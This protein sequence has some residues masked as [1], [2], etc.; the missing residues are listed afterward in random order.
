M[1]ERTPV[2]L[3]PGS[4]D[5]DLAE[6]KSRSVRGLLALTGRTFII[7][8]LSTAATFILTV[9][10]SPE[11]YGTFFLVSAVI[12]FLTYF[13]DIGLAAAL[14]QR[15]E[16]LTIKDLSTTFTVQQILVFSLVTVLLLLTTPIR[17]HYQL[18]QEGVFLMWS[19]AISLVLSSLKTIPTA[20]LEREL[21]FDKL[22]WP[23][24]AENIAYNLVVVYFAWKGYGITS[25]SFAVLVRGIVG[26]VAIYLIRPW[27]PTLGVHR[28]SLKHLLHFGLPYQL[29]TLLAV[30]KDDGMTLVLGGIVGQ[31]GL[32]YL[33]WANKWVSLPLRFFMDNITKVAFP[34]YAR[35]QHE[36]AILK[37]GVEK[38]IFFMALICFP[39]FMGMG[40]L[41]KPM[42]GLIPRYSKWE[43]ALFPFYMYLI[44]AAWASISTPLTNTLNA[45]GKIKSTFKLMIMWTVLTWLLMPY[46]GYHYG[47]RGVSLAAAIIAFS[48][49]VV[50]Y[51]VNQTIKLNYWSILRSPILASI[52]LGLVAW[53]FTVKLNGGQAI[54]GA[55]VGGSL[56]YGLVIYLLDR[57]RLKQE[58]QLLREHLPIKV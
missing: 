52:V 3:D 10:L 51:M 2:E 39:I 1:S 57:V 42:V 47:Y 15:R 5:V 16:N 23:Q 35:V 45:I 8:L 56:A 14:I 29:N 13:S 48:S 36:A 21:A 33:G 24:I 37:K 17:Q 4:I 46:L 27:R 25:F 7:Y 6:V 28:E 11:I 49:V 54:L 34:A 53:F 9:L 50:L 40:V 38:T 58:W 30:V 43:P 22:I 44:N 55:V 31:T 32:G 26:L 12:N 18:T 19:L 41:A 20:L